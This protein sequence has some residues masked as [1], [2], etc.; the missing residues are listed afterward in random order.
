M[1]KQHTH[2]SMPFFWTTEAV[3]S[4]KDVI[5]FYFDRLGLPQPVDR[6]SLYGSHILRWESAS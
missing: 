4:G 6:K 3:Q 2:D 5:G 1:F